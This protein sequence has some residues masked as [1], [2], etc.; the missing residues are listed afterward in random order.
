MVS[1]ILYNIQAYR[2]CARPF[3]QAGPSKFLTLRPFLVSSSVYI[4]LQY[5][6]TALY[7]VFCCCS[8]VSKSV[9]GRLYYNSTWRAPPH[10]T[11]TSRSSRCWASIRRRPSSRG[12]ALRLLSARYFHVAVTFIRVA[13]YAHAHARR[14]P[15]L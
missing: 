11:I 13:H 4:G 2:L 6:N 12:R 7:T 5:Y 10:R 14:S 8:I 1:V 15:L 3:D 9:S